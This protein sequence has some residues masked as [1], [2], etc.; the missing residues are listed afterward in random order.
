ML[1]HLLVDGL[2]PLE[3]AGLDA[4]P[5]PNGRGTAGGESQGRAPGGP[6]Q[7]G[8]Q[9]RDHRHREL[10]ALGPVDGENPHAVVVGLGQHRLG[11]PGVLGPLEAGPLQIAAQV[12]A[13]GVGPGPG[14]IDQ[15]PQPPPRVPG[16][17]RHHRR[18][19]RPPIPQQLLQQ[20]GRAGPPP[21]IVQLPQMGQAVGHRVA[22]VI[23]D[24]GIQR[25]PAPETQLPVGQVV[26]AATV[27]RRAQGGHRGQLVGGVGCRGQ[28]HQRVPH[29]PGGVHQRRGLDP[30]GDPG[31]VQ[32]R[33]QGREAGAGR[34]QDG[35]IAGSDR[36]PPRL[37][38]I[39]LV[40]LPALLDGGGHRRGHRGR[41]HPAQ[42]FGFEVVGDG[43]GADHGHGRAAA[44]GGPP[45]LQGAVLGLAPL[46][47]GD[48]PAEDGVDPFDD[49][50]D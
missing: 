14:L 27:Q 21:G 47:I 11:H 20:H 32:G 35:H 38:G 50:R 30:V 19:Q 40:H 42:L 22:G 37:V 18:L 45:G 12:A 15:E 23:S 2:P 44:A 8:G 26:V 1:V 36:P 3:T 28:G 9:A 39:A 13:A 16:P 34:H 25:E 6:G 33:L 43:I 49:A 5:E 17:A 29:L 31:S 7:L 24:V 10:E 46:L 48:E 41:L 4:G